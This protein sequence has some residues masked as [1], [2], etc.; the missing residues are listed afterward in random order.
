MAF[1]A[2]P[3]KALIPIDENK[4]NVVAI[5]VAQNETKRESKILR[6]NLAFVK[7]SL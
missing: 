6:Y 5:A 3:V 7:I 1:L 2:L 4:P